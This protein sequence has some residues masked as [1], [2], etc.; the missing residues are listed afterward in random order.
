MGIVFKMYSNESQAGKWPPVHGPEPWFLDNLAFPGAAD[1]SCAED[2]APEISPLSS[3]IYPEYLTD[4]AVLQC[5]S[6]PDTHLSI[7]GDV[8]EDG[9]ADPGVDCGI[10]TGQ[11]SNLAE[12]YVY[13]GYMLDMLDGDDPTVTAPIALDGRQPDISAQAADVIVELSA[14][15]LTTAAVTNGEDLREDKDSSV[16]VT[17]GLGNGGSDVVQRLREGIERF[18]IT[19]INNPAGSA[20]A[21]SQIYVMWDHVNINPTGAGEFNHLPGGS[22]ILYMD[23]H[24]AFQKYEQNGKGPINQWWSSTVYWFAG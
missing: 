14:V 7:V 22:N 15:L 16:D 18:L 17:S 20:Q 23:G 3:S 24:V 9:T 21:Q 6:D 10:Y 5:P 13:T 2:D 11:S 19:D 4:F 1:N 8:D 12:S